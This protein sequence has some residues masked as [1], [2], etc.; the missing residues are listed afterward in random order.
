MQ[1][2][3]DGVPQRI[4]THRAEATTDHSELIT[5][6]V[7]GDAKPLISTASCVRDTNFR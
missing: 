2:A 7:E 6:Q 3:D 1:H 5:G 4:C